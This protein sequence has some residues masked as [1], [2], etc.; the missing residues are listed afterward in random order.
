MFQGTPRLSSEMDLDIMVL[1]INDN[2][3]EFEQTSYF[4][5]VPENAAIGQIVTRIQATSRDTG[6]N[7]QISYYIQSGMG[8]EKF[9]IDPTSGKMADY[10]DFL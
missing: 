4:A 7:A 2:P 5:S 8:Q 3:P 10:D 6:I 9:A 1:D